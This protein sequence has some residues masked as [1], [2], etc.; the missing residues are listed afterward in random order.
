M[1]G[2]RNKLIPGAITQFNHFSI[3]IPLATAL[4]G[5][6]ACVLGACVRG[7]RGLQQFSARRASRSSPRRRGRWPRRGRRR[8]T[9]SRRSPSPICAKKAEINPQKMYQLNKI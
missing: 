2:K 4:L 7:A 5:A 3:S 8:R 1:R 9:G 6:G